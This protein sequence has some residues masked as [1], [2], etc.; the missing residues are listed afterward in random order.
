MIDLVNTLH[1]K[2]A[3]PHFNWWGDALLL[4]PSMVMLLFRK[5][6]FGKL[7]GLWAEDDEEGALAY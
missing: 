6:I 1:Y 4:V 7:P 3:S 2:R 5:R